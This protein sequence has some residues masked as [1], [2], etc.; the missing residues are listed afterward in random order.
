MTASI[1][2]LVG[3]LTAGGVREDCS[4]DTAAGDGEDDGSW[5]SMRE[6]QRTS[7]SCCPTTTRC[8]VE[9]RFS[10]VHDVSFI[11]GT[12]SPSVLLLTPAR[13]LHP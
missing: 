11:S 1:S 10:G 12:T 2:S 7:Q 3:L 13:F 4:S 9:R 6:V 8:T 5:P